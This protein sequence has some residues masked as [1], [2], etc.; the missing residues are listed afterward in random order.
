MKRSVP[1]VVT[2]T[3]RIV[4]SPDTTPTSARLPTN[5][6]KSHQEDETQEMNHLEER[7]GVEIIVMNK[8]PQGEVGTRRRST[9]TPR[10]TQ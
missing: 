8:D 4:G 7:E 1:L 10:G 5:E 9:S 3:A 2:E 6:E